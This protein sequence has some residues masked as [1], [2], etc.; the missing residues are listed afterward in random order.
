MRVELPEG[1]WAEIRGPET[2]RRKD[3]KAVLR[4][5][6]LVIDPDT[7]TAIVNGAN[8]QDMEDAMLARVI[9][10]WSFP[11]PLP[12]ADPESLGQLTL[13]QA[14]VLAGAVKPHLELIT[15][16]VD[17]NKRDSDPTAG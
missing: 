10:E 15:V 7:R 4:T 6:T 11:I 3:E 2:L 12:C 5:S 13:E 9:T 16:S 8:D 17:P 14:H 1:Q